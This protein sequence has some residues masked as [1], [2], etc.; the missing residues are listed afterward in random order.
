MSRAFTRL[1]EYIWYLWTRRNLLLTETP[2][3]KARVVRVLK[4][5]TWNQKYLDYEIE[6]L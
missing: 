4:G 1:M 2:M 3:V 6:T 5:R